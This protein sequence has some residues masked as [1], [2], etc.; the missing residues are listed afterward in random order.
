MRHHRLDIA[1]PLQVFIK[2]YPNNTPY[3]FQHKRKYRSYVLSIVQCLPC[4]AYDAFALSNS[5]LKL[6]CYFHGSWIP[7]FAHLDWELDPHNSLRVSRPQAQLSYLPLGDRL[8][9]QKPSSTYWPVSGHSAISATCCLSTLLSH[10]ARQPNSGFT[11][12]FW[13]DWA[14]WQKLSL[15]RM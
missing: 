12:R 8:T 2:M 3:I 15:V 1:L 13:V 10:L 6:E 7:A 5:V 4:L 9:G 14:L 11:M